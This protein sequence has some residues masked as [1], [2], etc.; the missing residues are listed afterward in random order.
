[1]LKDKLF[2]TGLL[3]CQP[4]PS[5]LPSQEPWPCLLPSPNG[6]SVHRA[7]LW[8]GGCVVVLGRLH[9]GNT[10]ILGSQILAPIQTPPLPHHSFPTPR[11]TPHLPAFPLLLQR[12][13][14][15]GKLPF[16][17]WLDKILDLVHDHL[18]D[19]WNDG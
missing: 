7:E 19:L 18:K 16:W 6:L 5:V 11:A 2:G 9:Q 13:S 12:E 17:T 14:P 3:S 4:Q 8:E 1:M 10:L 15:P